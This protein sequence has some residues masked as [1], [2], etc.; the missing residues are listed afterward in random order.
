MAERLERKVAFVGTSCIGKTALLE[1]YRERYKGDSNVAFVEE[2]ARIFFTHNEVHDRF[3]EE[4]QGRVQDLALNL[5]RQAHVS[6]A[7][8]T[9]CDRSVV[10]A[11][12]YVR[13]QGDLAG[14]RR[15]LER[16]AFWLPSYCA[17]VLLDP[18]DIPYATDEVRTESA[19]SREKFHQGFLETFE[20]ASIPYHL[21]GGTLLQRAWQID[22]IVQG[23]VMNEVKRF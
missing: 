18:A 4:T 5:E 11:S 15:L 1:H 23:Q 9:Y 20:E 22:T 14:S 6:G 12:A 10:D 2:A 17:I 3:S 16:V 13:A 8:T 19:E 21:V 7:S